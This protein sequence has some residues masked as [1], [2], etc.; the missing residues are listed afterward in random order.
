MYRNKVYESLIGSEVVH[1]HNTLKFASDNNLMSGSDHTPRISTCHT[2]RISIASDNTLILACY[3][4]SRVATNLRDPI[5]PITKD[6]D[7]FRSFKTSRNQL[8]SDPDIRTQ[9][10]QLPT[11][12]MCSFSFG[13][14]RNR[15]HCLAP[16]LKGRLSQWHH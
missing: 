8:E 1:N 4:I 6:C 5:V 15:G 7:S 9:S 2:P 14:G 3:H 16:N 12:L 10:H 13:V 11:T